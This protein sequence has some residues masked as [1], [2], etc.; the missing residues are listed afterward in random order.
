MMEGYF[1]DFFSINNNNEKTIVHLGF[2]FLLTGQRIRVFH[3][4]VLPPILFCRYLRRFFVFQLNHA[5]PF[6]RNI[7]NWKRS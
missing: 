1:Q 5:N 3:L 6:L 2:L 7:N 4:P